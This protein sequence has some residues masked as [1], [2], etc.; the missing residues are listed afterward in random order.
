MEAPFDLSRFDSVIAE[1][2]DALTEAYRLGLP[3]TARVRAC[4][5]ALILHPSLRVEALGRTLSRASRL[6]L[7][8]AISGFTRALHRR[9]SESTVLAPYA[10]TAARSANGLQNTLLKLAC[11]ERDDFVRPLLV[12]EVESG[13]PQIDAMLNGCW[14]DVFAECANVSFWTAS[15]PAPIGARTRGGRRATFGQRMR[16]GWSRLPYRA[17]RSISTML[18]PALPRGDLYV[19]RENELLQETALWLALRGCAIH[20]LEMP[21]PRSLESPSFPAA[22]EL[23]IAIDAEAADRFGA[24]LA[25]PARSTASK[26]LAR[27]IR[28]DV[29]V[30]AS[31]ESYWRRARLSRHPV[32]LA[33]A[34]D[35]PLVAG[36]ARVLRERGGMLVGFQHGL[37]REIVA[38]RF[39][40]P[41]FN[42]C[43][44]SDLTMG[45]SIKGAQHSNRNPYARG[46]TQ[47]V[48]LP[49]DY[50]RLGGRRTSKG[51]GILFVSTT[52]Y[53]GYVQRLTSLLDDDERACREIAL[54]EN[55]LATLP[56][57][58]TFKPY[59]SFRYADPC[60]IVEAA[61]GA[62]GVSVH[63]EDIDL[64][65]LI[66]NYDVVVTSG[67][68][69]TVGWCAMS[70]LP[71]V[72]ID[73]PDTLG[74]ADSVRSAFADAF[75]L[76][77]GGAPDLHMALTRFL[78]QPIR[79]IQMQARAKRA[80][81]DAL[82][83][84][85]FGAVGRGAGRRAARLIRVKHRELESG[86]RLPHAVEY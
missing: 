30:Q 57:P 74:L 40:S 7:M 2:A 47:A 10:V 54:I 15:T 70:G 77:D 58:V 19:L 35:S 6:D 38:E 24:V 48:G 11:L 33:N 81:R 26:L 68:T 25:G 64:R 43:A 45:F 63:K 80:A 37:G 51:G 1:S 62:S 8:D 16:L 60:V 78:S 5:P 14:P 56:H 82:L 76:F 79:S 49:G 17:I 9:M 73:W 36:L 86:L 20:A 13:R 67:A 84:S 71:I 22:D 83:R 42:E 59:P 44:I 34:P 27:R 32:V 66:R 85:V 46:P 69:S 53:L 28:S 23:H 31:A 65:Y 18:R 21:S 41:I 50:Y 55:V 75:F 39:D 3:R 52:L 29:L 72:F 12:L 61:R 4:S